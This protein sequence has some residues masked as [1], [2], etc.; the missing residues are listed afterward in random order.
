VSVVVVATI[1][2]R[3][4]AVDAVRAALL[5]AVPAVHAEPGCEL[6]AL[7]EADGVFVMVERWESPEALR[8]HGK[9]EALTTLGAALADKLAAPP[10]VRRLTAV[11]A[12]DPAKGEVRPGA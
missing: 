10:E 7:H 2:P 1:T 12:G 4:D 5:D 6:Y 9:A 11:P 8:A 3:P